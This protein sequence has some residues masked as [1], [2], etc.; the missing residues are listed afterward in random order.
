MS[1][2]ADLRGEVDEL[3]LAN[4]ILV[5]Q[6]ALDAFGHV[7]VRSADGHDKF[8]LSRSMAPGLVQPEDVLAFDLEGQAVLQTAAK[9]YLERFIHSEIYR[10]RPDVIAIVHGHSPGVVTF[11]LTSAPLRPV[12]HM[13]AFLRGSVPIFDIRAAVGDSDM[14][15]RSSSLGSALAEVLGESSVVLQRG[16]GATVVGSSLR[17]AVFRSIYLEVNARVQADA[18][19]LGPVTFLSPGEAALASEAIDTQVDRAWTVWAEQTR[20]S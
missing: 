8:L 4:R 20:K 10:A 1:P 19:R 14:L 2:P 11:G 18:T 17:A 3:V 6:G 9:P 7:S 5:A 16:H 12:F 15:I 13:S